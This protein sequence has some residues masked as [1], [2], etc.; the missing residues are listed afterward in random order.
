[1]EGYV[2][3]T[4]FRNLKRECRNWMY[5]EERGRWEGGGAGGG[6][7]GGGGG[8]GG[9]IIW[10]EIIAGV[11]V[12]KLGETREEYVMKKEGGIRS[13]EGNVEIK[14]TNR[15]S[16]QCIKTPSQS[17]PAVGAFCMA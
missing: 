5:E 9:G 13:D 16:Q 4:D 10:R 2:I 15:R 7:R 14:G 1:M 17:T 8:G 3:T 6:G 12:C 11:L